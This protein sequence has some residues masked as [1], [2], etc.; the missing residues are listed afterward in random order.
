M[1]VRRA[2]K[3][4]TVRSFKITSILVIDLFSISPQFSLETGYSSRICQSL[5]GCLFIGIQLFIA[6][7]YDP[8]YF[9]GVHCSFFFLI[10][11]FIDSGPLLFLSLGIKIYV[12]FIFSNMILKFTLHLL[13]LQNIGLYSLCCA[14]HLCSLSYTQKFASP[15]SRLILLLSVSPMAA[16]SLFSVSVSLFL[17]CYIH[18]FVLF[19]YF[20]FCFI[21]Q[22]AYI[23]DIMQC[24]SF[25][26]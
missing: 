21:F 1:G 10:S 24:L 17:F 14:I 20:L 25:S 5:L 11:D 7:F 8:L 2:R 16:I 15:T 13:L 6:V 18:Q 22:V 26:V 19:I 23:S 3:F 9:C 12:L 4:W